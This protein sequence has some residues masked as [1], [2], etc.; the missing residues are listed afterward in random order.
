MRFNA[1]RA[2]YWVSFVCVDIDLPYCALDKLLSVFNL[3]WHCDARSRE[4]T[5]LKAG[6]Y[7]F[8]E[9]PNKATTA[10]LFTGCDDV[11]PF[12]LARF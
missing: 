10:S 5:R 1:T 9:L 2:S 7:L 12:V 8:S 4:A 11:P 3:V 6:N